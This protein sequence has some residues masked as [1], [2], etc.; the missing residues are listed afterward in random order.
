MFT[1][2]VKAMYPS[3]PQDLGIE[4]VRKALN[5][6]TSQKPS[7]ANLVECLKIC[8]TENHFEF[9]D[10][11]F[12]QVHGTS[13]GPKMA[14]GY[15]CLGMGVVE[16]RP[17]DTCKLKPSQWYRYI[18]DIWGLWPHGLDEFN[19]FM[20]TLNNLFPKVLE[21]TSTF[22]FQ[23]I[24]FLDLLVFRTPEGFLGTDLYVKPFLKHFYIKYDSFYSKHTL[25]NIAYG[26]AIRIKTICST[27]ESTQKNL[28][29]LHNNLLDRGYPVEIV[30]E[31]I[32]KAC[33]YSRRDLLKPK[34]CPKFK[35]Q[36]RAPL[37]VT[38]NPRL[39]PLSSI[40][41]K[42]FPILKLSNTFREIFP[43]PPAVIYRQPPN[44]RSL[45]VKDKIQHDTV[46]KG[47]FKTHDKC[48]VTCAVLRDTKTFQSFYTGQKFFVQGDLTCS[49]TGVI[50]LLNCLDCKKQYVG[51]TGS[52]LRIRHRGH[53]QE[54]KRGHTPIGKHFQTCKQ[55]E[56]IAIE[57]LRNNN[58][59]V[60]EE[61]ELHWIFKLNTLAPVGM[62]VKDV[63][64]SR[65]C[66]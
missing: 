43:N 30:D 24:P 54:F 4:G 33:K 13:I 37:V 56:L 65:E 16:E 17:W 61:R 18:D 20:D 1:I 2:D 3:M 42:H 35:K 26:Q 48:C 14:P 41:R 27:E 31:K 10:K 32:Q 52:E 57:K 38:R 7:T 36:F 11:Y 22:G 55:F 28:N 59:R 9:N 21:F 46:S 53:R 49:T 5:S 44:L 23:S 6:R 15:A 60:R 39:P 19:V 45:L 64:L 47:C 25:D 34:G 66:T 51:E 62:N 50:Y 63:S 40:V 29:F 12:T 8:L 58:K